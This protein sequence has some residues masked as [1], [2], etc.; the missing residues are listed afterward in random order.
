MK[1]LLF[2]YGLTYGGAVVAL[3]NPFYGLLIY[4][5]FAILRPPALW[6][7]SVPPSNYS[8]IIAIAMLIG[9][10]L[11]G[12]GNWRL[13][14]AWGV[15]GAIVGLWLWSVMS[16]ILAA[17]DTSHAF[18]YVTL[19]AK[20][21]L[22][23]LV[24]ITTINSL[25]QLK[26][27]AWVIALSQSYVAY[28]MNAMYFNGYNRFYLQ[29]FGG[30]DNNVNSIAMATGVGLALFLALDAPRW[31]QKAIALL[32]AVLMAHSI[33]FAFSRG[34][35]LGLIVIAGVGFY[36]LPKK[37]RHYVVFAAVVLVALRLAGPEVR[38]RFSSVFLDEEV[39]DFSAQS[40][41]EMWGDC[42]TLMQENPIL[43][44]GPD[45]W[46]KMAS[47]FGWNEGKEAHSLWL[48]TGAELGFVGLGF[49][50]AYYG[51]CCARLRRLAKARE[52]TVDPFLH[53]TARMVI[54]SV[55][56]F[57]VSASFVTVEALEIPYYVALLGA[58]ALKLSPYYDIEPAAAASAAESD[59]IEAEPATPGPWTPF[60]LHPSTT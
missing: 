2:T 19:L 35:M 11:A 51:L 60:P 37:P 12:F 7:W 34:G 39:R 14:R 27:L 28:E 44:V 3:F 55:A 40:R 46:P 59:G 47:R 33:M 38:E 49:L 6:Y 26:Q 8:E 54:A 58:G 53:S 41:W 50:L 21:V 13:G 45:H 20:I 25:T 15:I 29:G 17:G 1:G 57:A 10:A 24:G 5:C 52:P 56:G 32:G 16:A 31:W 48:Q 22:P 36:L 43:G 30:A 9:W 4:I 42:W 18:G 23:I